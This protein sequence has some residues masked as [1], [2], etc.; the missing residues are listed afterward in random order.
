LASQQAWL[1]GFSTKLLIAV[2]KQKNHTILFGIKQLLSIMLLWFP[3]IL[4]SL[5]TLYLRQRQVILE[6]FLM[7]C[8]GNAHRE[9]QKQVTVGAAVSLSIN[10]QCLV[11]SSAVITSLPTAP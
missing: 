3:G 1:E 4:F 2:C 7:E 5:A 8:C 6:F 9:Q 10:S 11:R